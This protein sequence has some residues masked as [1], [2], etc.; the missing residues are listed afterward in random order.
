MERTDLSYSGIEY[1]YE[2]S[3]CI[4]HDWPCR[5][6][7]IQNT[8]IESININKVMTEFLH[9]N[10]IKIN[11]LTEIDLYCFDRIC[12]VNNIWDKDLYEVEVRPGY[13]GEEIDG[14]FFANEKKI[15]SEFDELLKLN[16]DIDKIKYILKLEY[17]YVI[18]SITNC[19]NVIVTSCSPKSVISP[20][21]EYYHRLEKEVVESYR[22]Y[23]IPCAVCKKSGDKYLIIDGYHRVAA[24]KNKDNIEI[25]VID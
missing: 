23:K 11:N 15:V 6:T 21:R 4:C 19:H 1:D 2:R 3:R 14:V 10:F 12:R 9:N 13:Y 16:S 7:T 18:D 5:C 17:G 20:Q 22:D 8:W 24:N 25:I